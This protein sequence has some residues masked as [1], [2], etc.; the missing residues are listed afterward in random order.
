MID[1][2]TRKIGLG[3]QDFTVFGRRGLAC[4]STYLLEHLTEVFAL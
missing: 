3:E 2:Y 1:A 4:G